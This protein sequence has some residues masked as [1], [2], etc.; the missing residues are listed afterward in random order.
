MTFNDQ[1]T[2]IINLAAVDRDAAFTSVWRFAAAQAG[3]GWYRAMP[4]VVAVFGYAAQLLRKSKLVLAHRQRAAKDLKFFA[5]IDPAQLMFRA[6]RHDIEVLLKLV[7]ELYGTPAV[8]WQR[9]LL[10]H[11]YPHICSMTRANKDALAHLGVMPLARV[12][13]MRASDG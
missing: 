9:A 2:S 12:A 11:D 3:G 5:P 13:E 6:K 7:K 1:L 10:H 8:L 4:S